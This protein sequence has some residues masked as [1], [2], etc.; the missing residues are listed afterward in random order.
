[1]PRP[2]ASAARSIL[3]QYMT[4]RKDAR[5]MTRI[6]CKQDGPCACATTATGLECINEAKYTAVAVRAV[7]RTAQRGL[8][9]KRI[10]SRATGH[11]NSVSICA[12]AKELAEARDALLLRQSKHGRRVEDVNTG[13]D[14]PEKQVSKD[15]SNRRSRI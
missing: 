5:K 10:R 2:A 8:K 7:T 13:V 1:M 12:K 11:C 6:A 14:C 15:G 4:S 9:R 3:R